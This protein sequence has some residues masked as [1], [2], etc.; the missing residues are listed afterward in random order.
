MVQQ[1]TIFDAVPVTDTFAIGDAV[2]V[3]INVPEKDVEVYY[4]HKTYEG[5]EGRIVK[6]LPRQE[7]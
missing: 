5:S 7:Y 3:V 4:Y 2:E 1:L 6:V